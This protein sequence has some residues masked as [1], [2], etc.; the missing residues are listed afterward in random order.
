MAITAAG[1]GSGLQLEDIIKASLDARRTQFE[2]RILKQET[3]LKTSLS[4]VGQLKSAL[5]EFTKLSKELAKADA[6]NLRTINITQ[7]KDNPVLK[8]EGQLGASNGNYDIIVNN[9]ASGSKFESKPGAFSS[10]SQVIATADGQLTFSAGADKSFT[11]DVK[12][13]DTLND[14][15]G[16]INTNGK[17]FGLSTNIVNQGG[18]SKLIFDSSVTGT[19][20]DLTISASTPELKIFDTSDTSSKLTSTKTAI[21]A[22]VSIDGV[23]VSNKTN[24]LDNVIQGMKVTLLRESD[25]DSSAK[26]I[27]NKVAITTD[28]KG[29]K[30]KIQSFITAY[31][32]LS[33]TFSALGKRP[34]IV[35]GKRND[36]GGLLAGDSTLRSISDFMFSTLSSTNTGGE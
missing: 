1:A 16:K 34:T 29:I 33:D 21:D 6:F 18:E 10:S 24:I 9:L 36:D 28:T 5:S 2:S 19:G 15:R 20:N 4:G 17:N 23:T 14:L 13:G 12:A 26:P 27:A 32:T 30:D 25:K 7:S 31:N 3:T 8:V 35:A 11:V 22:S